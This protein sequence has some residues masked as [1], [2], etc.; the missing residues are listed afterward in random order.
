M[1]PPEKPFVLTNIFKNVS[2]MKEGINVY[3]EEEEH[4]G[5]PWRIYTVRENNHFGIFLECSWK[6]EE[7]WTIQAS[8]DV[9]LLSVNGQSMVKS[10]DRS[11][12]NMEGHNTGWGWYTFIEWDKLMKNFVS[13]DSVIVEVCVKIRQMTGIKLRNFAE[14]NKQFS[15]VVL[16]VEDQKFHVSKLY[17]ASQSTYFNS[18]LLGNFEES[19]KSEIE[20]KDVKSEDFQKFLE[21]LYGESSIDESTIEGILH[22]SDMYDAK[23]A[24]RKCEEFLV[25]NSN[26]TLEEKLKLS[27]R[28]S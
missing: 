15:D 4:F 9:K 24:V 1:P 21:L 22:L 5:V 8:R 26:N 13:D 2:E 12:G 10:G 14:S 11:F 17:L 19:K 28:Y 18:L 27:Y 25:E 6:T 16:I 3:S 20:I 7:K 23:L